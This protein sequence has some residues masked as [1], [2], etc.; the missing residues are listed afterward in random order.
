LAVSDD[1]SYIHCDGN[2]CERTTRIPIALRPRQTGGQVPPRS[3]WLYVT[4]ESGQQHYCP[5]CGIV[6][7][8]SIERE[9]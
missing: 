8:D 3:G 5:A 7:L 9:T 1:K 4:S 6:Y 2:G